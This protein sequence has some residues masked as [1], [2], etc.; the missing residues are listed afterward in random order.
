MAP[1]Q[2]VKTIVKKKIAVKTRV[3][4]T[5]RAQLKF[6]VGRIHR[7]LRQGN[8]AN[9]ISTS[10]AVFTAGVLE[11]LTAEICEVAGDVANQN[12]KARITPRHIMKTIK[13]DAEFSEL[14]KDVNIPYAGVLPYIHPVLLPKASK[15]KKR[16]TNKAKLT[17]QG[18]SNNDGELNGGDSDVED[19]EET[20]SS[21]ESKE[22]SESSVEEAESTE[23]AETAEEDDSVE[24]EF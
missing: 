6:P 20:N 8:Y 4:K 17:G 14:L 18:A 9:R 22:E 10:A 19:E 3:S 11:Y 7:H 15:E 5:K 1:K 16:T 24:F 21:I 12:K 23:G 13:D 2:P